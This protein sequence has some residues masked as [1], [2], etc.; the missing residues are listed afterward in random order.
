MG[1]FKNLLR[2]NFSKCGE[3]TGSAFNGCSLSSTTKDGLPALV[4]YGVGKQDYIFNKNDIKEFKVIESGT[5]KNF[6]NQTLMITKY[7][8]V[9][10]DGKSAILSVPV[11]NSSTIEKVLY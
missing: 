4:I 7:S 5:F 10:N 1:F 3:V 6:G 9:F 8:V 11:G 2:S